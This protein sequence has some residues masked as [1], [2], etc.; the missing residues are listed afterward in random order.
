MT[1]F[2]SLPPEL[3]EQIYFGLLVHPLSDANRVMLTLN[4]DGQPVW[5]RITEISPDDDE[6]DTGIQPT[7]TQSSI[8]HMDYSNLWSL[9]R[10]NRLLYRETVPIIY[11]NACL[12]YTFGD[13]C[14]I[15]QSP[16]LLRAFVDKLPSATC[17]LYRQLTIVNGKDL[18]AKV[19][20]S[21]VDIIN[22]ELPNL[23]SLEIRAIDPRIEALINGE[24]PQFISEC[25]DMMAAARPLGHLTSSPRITLKP[26]VS[27]YL[28]C[29]YPTDDPNVK[30]L[31]AVMQSLVEV[32]AVFALLGIRSWR[33][34][35]QEIHAMYCE[36]GSYLQLT[37]LVRS[38]TYENIE[39]KS[40][41]QIEDMEAEL[42]EY[43]E[44]LKQIARCKRWVTTLDGWKRKCR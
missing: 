13:S 10:V 33:R 11:A 6:F 42:M 22:T 16:S 24:A 19:M 28:E 29:D 3:R 7:L 21:I 15:S 14:S 30:E 27:F 1:N 36:E 20:G 26:R 32:E 34:Q 8:K 9:A 25:I 2:L 4:K 17:A 38:Q 43:Q 23:D 41:D 40:V 12:E 35:A 5:D 31:M 39:T 18:S 44:V 37:S